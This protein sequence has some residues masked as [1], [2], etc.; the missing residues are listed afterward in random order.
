MRLHLKNISPYVHGLIKEHQAEHGHKNLDETIECI[1]KE[2][3]MWKAYEK[4]ETEVNDAEG[5]I[6]NE[7]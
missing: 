5:G 3:A 4:H 6:I 7:C 1:V 2:H